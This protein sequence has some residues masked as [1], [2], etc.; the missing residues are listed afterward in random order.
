MNIGAKRATNRL[1]FRIIASRV[2]QQNEIMKQAK[3]DHKF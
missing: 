1:L 2:S 3:I